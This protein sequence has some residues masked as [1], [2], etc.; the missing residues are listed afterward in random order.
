MTKEEVLSLTPDERIAEIARRY[1]DII[2]L[3]GEDPE[4]EGLVKTPLRAAKALWF[5]TDGYRT[6]PAEILGGALFERPGSGIVVVRDIEFHSMCEHHILPFFG[7]VSIAYLPGEHIVGL[8]KIARI[9]NV[10]ARRLQVQERFT[11]QL[12]D[13]ILGDIGARGVMVRCRAE[14]L[15]MKMRGVEKQCPATVTLEY[16][17]V[18]ATDPAARTEALAQLS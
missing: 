18:F 7:T 4:R 17:G 15:C 12:C 9:V 5:C 14:H 11:R 10:F 2:A 1:A 8:S 3:I 16:N 13:E 6:D